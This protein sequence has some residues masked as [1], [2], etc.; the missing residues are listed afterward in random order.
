[1]RRQGGPPQAE[2]PP[3]TRPRTHSRSSRPAKAFGWDAGSL[4]TASRKRKGGAAWRFRKRG[5][6]SE[7][8][9]GEPGE[10][11]R[12]QYQSLVVTFH[13]SIA[14]RIVTVLLFHDSFAVRIL[15]LFITIVQP[16]F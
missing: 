8:G 5:P 9:R 1:M 3:R 2:A 11:G 7:E 16:G 15:T 13:Y 14:A 6:A 12:L 4:A 10:S